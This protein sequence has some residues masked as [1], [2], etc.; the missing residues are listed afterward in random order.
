MT[1]QPTVDHHH[2]VQFYGDEEDLFKTVS[3]FLSEGLIAGQPA[4]IIATPSHRAALLDRLEARLINVEKACSGC[5]L[6]VLDAAETLG[7]FMVG[8]FP[9][10]NAFEANVGGVIQRILGDR[11]QAV[12]RAYGEMVDVLWKQE[13][14]DA[15]IRLEMLWNKLAFTH[16]FAL[17]CGYAI[18]NFYKQAAQLHEVR[19]Q[20]AHIIEPG[21]SVVMLPRR[22]GETN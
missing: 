5:D 13:R 14:K 22:I 21:E 20:H 15:A 2:A 17:L 4:L 6:T 11:P 16:G 3:S 19:S 8:D 7:L 1:D 18:G 12:L 10:P 9:D